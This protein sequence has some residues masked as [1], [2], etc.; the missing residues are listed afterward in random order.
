MRHKLCRGLLVTALGAL[1]AQTEAREVRLWTTGE[2]VSSEIYNYSQDEVPG[3]WSRLEGQGTLGPVVLTTAGDLIA[4]DNVSA[5]CDFDEQGNPIAIPL[6]YL[7]ASSVIR[8]RRGDQL[9]TEQASS[10]PSTICFNF[11]TGSLTYELYVDVVGGTGRFAGAMG[12]LVTRGSGQQLRSVG[13]FD[14]YTEG[15]LLFP[16]G[17]PEADD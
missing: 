10:P 14:G 4:Y 6:E 12:T 16:G 15:T 8:T 1:A 5:P 13:P 3:F 11:L 2:S 17:E 7:G 9:Y